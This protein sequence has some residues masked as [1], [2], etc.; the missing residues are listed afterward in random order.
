MLVRVLVLALGIGAA[1]CDTAKPGASADAAV[2]AGRLRACYTE[3]A[4]DA[5]RPGDRCYFAQPHE[6]DPTGFCAPAEG[7]CVAEHAF[8]GVDGQ[9]IW[10]CRFPARPWRHAGRCEDAAP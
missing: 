10:A 9:T 7:R 5:L 2:D 3:A 8:C 6:K 4:C 1:A